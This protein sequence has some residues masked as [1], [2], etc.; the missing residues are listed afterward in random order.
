VGTACF[1]QAACTAAIA[2]LLYFLP[3]L[4]RAESAASGEEEA[5]VHVFVNLRVKTGKWNP[6]VIANL[7]YDPIYKGTVDEQL[8]EAWRHVKES[9]ALF[10]VRCHN[11]FSDS[12]WGCRVYSEDA[13]GRPRYDWSHLDRVLGTFLS[14]GVRP[15]IECDFMPD[16]LAAGEIVRNYS[17]GAINLPNDYDKWRNLIQAL[18]QHCEK[19]YGRDE[20]R[21]WYFEVWNE[22]DVVKYWIGGGSPTRYENVV[23]FFRLY[24]YFAAGAKEADPKVRVGGPALGGCNIDYSFARYFLIHCVR[25]ENFATGK[26]EGAP[27]DFVSWH[28]YGDLDYILDVNERY[29]RIIEEDAPTLASCEFHLTEWGQELGEGDNWPRTQNHYEAAFTCALIQEVLK[30]ETARI[31]L[32]LRW[33][34]LTGEYFGGWRSLFTRVGQRTVPVALF[35]L[36]RLFGKM[37]ATRVNVITNVSD[38]SAGA[39]ATSDAP[40]TLQLLLWRFDEENHESTGPEQKFAVTVRGVQER[41]RSIKAWEYRIDPDHCDAW[42]EWKQMSSPKPAPKEQADAIAEKAMLTVAGK[43]RRLPVRDGRVIVTLNLRPN[44]ICLLV[45]GEEGIGRNGRAAQPIPSAPSLPTTLLP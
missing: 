35:N 5:P 1:K 25:G 15:I 29:R 22:P 44:S 26:K 12:N 38:R 21:R 18:V 17:G 27:I 13:S 40:N 11:V 37:S 36:Y 34:G 19:Q 10:Y 9:E 43:E 23:R 41:F 24:D 45:L 4:A 31:D 7:G 16:T 33:G 32:M 30:E 42:S 8:K 14:A 28:A 3:A 20:V 6:A 2:W 39:I